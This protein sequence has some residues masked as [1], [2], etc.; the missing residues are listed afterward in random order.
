MDFINSSMLIIHIVTGYIALL[1]G[2]LVMILTKGNERHRIIGR[3]F[4]YCM[5]GVSI[6]SVFLSISKALPFLLQIGIFVFYQTYGGFSSVKD[7]TLGIKI[8][9]LIILLIALI[10]GLFM[11]ISLNLILL[12]FGGITMLLVFI[13]VRIYYRLYRKISIDK[14]AWLSRHIG[15][16]IGSY[17]GTLTAFLVVNFSFIKPNWIVW[18]APTI[19][20]V[21]LMR[22]WIWKNTIIKN[23]K[24]AI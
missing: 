9:D 14:K 4:F 1:S 11:I 18:L 2:G 21:P 22:Y 15:M 12:I 6:T 24:E 17:I 16:M 10:N 20:L 13:D 23:Q 8:P 19:L 3:V 7:K 5:I